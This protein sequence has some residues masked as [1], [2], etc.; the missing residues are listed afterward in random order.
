MA[1]V[2]ACTIIQAYYGSRWRAQETMWG[3][4]ACKVTKLTYNGE[5]E[6]R[7]V[8]ARRQA[9]CKGMRVMCV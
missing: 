3:L 5:C 9:G 7:R 8:C 1:R 6:G 2:Y 4:R